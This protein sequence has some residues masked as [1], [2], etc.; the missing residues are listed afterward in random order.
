MIKILSTLIIAL[1]M[2]VS[3]NLVMAETQDQAIKPL[4]LQKIMQDM[5]K[6]MQEITNGISHEDWKRVKEA[7]LKIADHPKPP[8]TEKIRILSFV[9]TNVTKFKS[10]DGK[11]HDTALRLKEAAAKKNG[12]Q[13][14]SNFSKLQTT[15]LD[16]HQRFRESFQE[17][18]YGQQ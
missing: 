4:V 5:N 13:V 11:T 3:T 6:N 9:G 17:H 2:T 16:C 8:F 15:C 12:Y 1:G 7:A 14:I 18:F 10:F